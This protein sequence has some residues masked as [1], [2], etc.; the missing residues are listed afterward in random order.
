[1]SGRQEAACGLVGSDTLVTF[2]GYNP[3]V[4]VQASQLVK[5]TYTPGPALA[6]HASL[7]KQGAHAIE[8]IL[9]ASSCAQQ[10]LAPHLHHTLVKRTA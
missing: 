4:P 8:G 6:F 9:S 5:F 10:F 7:G 2:G 1:M 3:Y